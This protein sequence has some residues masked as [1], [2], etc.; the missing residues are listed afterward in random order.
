VR[1][2]LHHHSPKEKAKMK[3]TKIE[4]EMTVVE[5]AGLE[6]LAKREGKTIEEFVTEAMRFS[7]EMA[8]VNCTSDEACFVDRST[9]AAA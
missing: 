6:F 1:P 9:E 7:L 4:F 3:I 2:K 5:R 8:E